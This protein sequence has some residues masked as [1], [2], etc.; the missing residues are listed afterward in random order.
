MQYWYNVRT[1]QVEADDVKSRENDLLGPYDTA[2]EAERALETARENT[3]AW[4]E[5]DRAWED[6]GWDDD[7]EEDRA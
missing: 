4:D 7:E 6:E 3:E 1:G 2:E 5:E